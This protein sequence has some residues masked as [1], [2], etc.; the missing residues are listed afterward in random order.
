[1]WPPSSPSTATTV[2]STLFFFFQLSLQAWVMWLS[3]LNGGRF[4]TRCGRLRPPQ[5]ISLTHDCY[6]ILYLWQNAS[7]VLPLRWGLKTLK[8]GM[9]IGINW[10]FNMQYLMFLSHVYWVNHAISFFMNYS[11]KLIATKMNLWDSVCVLF[12]S[13]ENYFSAPWMAAFSPIHF[14]FFYP[15][16]SPFKDNCLQ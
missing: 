6:K 7:S 12:S 1:M 16:S 11:N 15:L 4:L 5:S 13:L 9:C 14:Y 3:W 10:N 2:W 8:S